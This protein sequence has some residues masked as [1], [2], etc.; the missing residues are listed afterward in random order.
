MHQKG[1]F[2]NGYSDT[3]SIKAC[4]SGELICRI[5]TTNHNVNVAYASIISICLSWMDRPSLSL[6]QPKERQPRQGENGWQS[7]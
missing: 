5:A 7:N 6:W 2:K 1:V 4:E 3:Q